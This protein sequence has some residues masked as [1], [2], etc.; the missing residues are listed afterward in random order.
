M[1]GAGETLGIQGPGVW[2]LLITLD[3]FGRDFYVWSRNSEDVVKRARPLLMSG[4]IRPRTQTLS[5]EWSFVKNKH[6]V[7]SWVENLWSKVKPSPGG[8]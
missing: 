5:R 4:F 1:R 2:S 8:Y 3:N 6:A 7:P